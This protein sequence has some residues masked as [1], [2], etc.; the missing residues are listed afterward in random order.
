VKVNGI[1]A[2]ILVSK[3][4]IRTPVHATVTTAATAATVT[5]AMLPSLVQLRQIEIG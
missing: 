5:F 4:T 2:D 1:C 3:F